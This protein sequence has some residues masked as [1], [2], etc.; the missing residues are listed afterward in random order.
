MFLPRQLLVLGALIASPAMAQDHD[1]GAKAPVATPAT[2][3]V[4]PCPMMKPAADS[5]A[6][7]AAGAMA[8]MPCM[9]AMKKAQGHDHGA[10]APLAAPATPP[11]TPCP[12]MKPAA[13][14]KAAP[15]EGAVANMPCMDAMKKMHDQTPA[16]PP[17]GSAPVAPHDH[18]HA[19][20]SPD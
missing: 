7:P 5:K 10:K 15:A 14:G 6:A 16:T 3:P 2:P 13:D 12:M 11:V 9:D 8:N 20:A 19:G 17:T 4:T 18:D 1:H